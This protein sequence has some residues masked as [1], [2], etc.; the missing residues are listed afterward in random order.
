MTTL[1]IKTK[2]KFSI[3]WFALS[4]IENNMNKMKEK[5]EQ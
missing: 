1:K 4:K 5:E 2:Q 3:L